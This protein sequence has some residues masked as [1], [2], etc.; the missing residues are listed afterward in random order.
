[1]KGNVHAVVASLAGAAV[2]LAAAG[3]LMGDQPMN[4]TIPPAGEILGRLAKDH[5]RVMARAADFERIGKRVAAG[6]PS[7]KWFDAVK[8][9]ADKL[10]DAA[11]SK[12]EIPDGK[13][14]LATSRR[15]L[16]RVTTLAL[17]YRLTGERRYADRAW[18]EL[19]AAAA[20]KNWNP[21]HFLDTAEMTQA[22]A[23]GYDWLYDVWSAEQRKVLREA[24]VRLG[25]EPGLAC[26]EGR[27]KSN[28]WPKCS[29]NWNQVCNGGL[30]T[31]ALAIAD[32]E[33]E[34]AGK[35][36]ELG[37]RSV[38]LPMAEFAPDGAWAE[39]P[40]YW[41]YAVRYN[42]YLLAAL[43]T[44]LGT[45]FGLAGA[46]EGFDETGLFPIHMTSPLGITFNF[47]DV[48]ANHRIR[49]PQM[50]WLARRFGRP[51]YALYQYEHARPEALDL[52]WD[53][54][55]R[56]KEVAALPTAK[57]FR[58]CDVVTMRSGWGPDAAFVG[59]KAGAN[60]V[61]HSHLDLGSFVLDWRGKRWA[62][63]LGSDNYN[64]PG[65]F[66]TGDQ[67]WAYYRLRAEGHNTLVINPGEG[68]DQP[69]KARAA[70]ARFE[71]TPGRTTAA[72][73]LTA[74]YALHAAKIERTVELVGDERVTV[75]DAVKLKAPG[76]VWWF[77]HTEAQVALGDDGR[78]AVLTQDGKSVRVEIVSPEAA[79]FTVM[80]AQPLG[81]SPNPKEQNP[82]KDVRKL[83][84]HLEKVED[85]TIAVRVTVP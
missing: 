34:L 49:A 4:V 13:R 44:A 76:D 14:L 51:H 65:Y 46:A 27:G 20:F 35:I 41:H 77:W 48:G 59:F 9:E 73:D 29:H 23:L 64:M 53:P 43:E 2:L 10:F 63:D 56:G 33:P 22:F 78:S 18:A 30:V 32:E 39:G 7:A 84:I 50:F 17:V 81:T 37:L 57:W 70:I 66:A 8:R 80:P 12:Y 75:T 61:N 6:G 36:I 72:A 71:H 24:I 3:H 38:Q 28:W 47:A 68:P 52:L 11:P 74:A 16:D 60:A 62:V 42:V 25:L 15:V 21:P 40:G 82:N 5:P 69:P 19:A 58:G 31:G 45:D 26:H 83:A 55:L 67:R 1:M 85:V 54:L 79:A